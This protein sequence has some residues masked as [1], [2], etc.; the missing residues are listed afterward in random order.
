MISEVDGYWFEIKQIN[1]NHVGVS[2]FVDNPQK[3]REIPNSAD[4]FIP[5]RAW[6]TEQFLPFIVKRDCSVPPP[7][8]TFSEEKIL[9]EC[10]RRSAEAI[11]FE[12][13]KVGLPDLVSLTEDEVLRL[14]LD[15][16]PRTGAA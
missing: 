10:A 12:I 5:L 11:R 8:K 4:Q 1:K 7:V 14:I 13:V 3:P 15:K 2:V 6:L 9:A 16:R